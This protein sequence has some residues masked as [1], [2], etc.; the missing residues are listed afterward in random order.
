MKKITFAFLLL[1]I[2]CMNLNAQNKIENLNM[3]YGEELP[4]DKQKIIKIIGEANNKIYALALAGKDDFFLKIFESNSMKIISSNPI[5]IPKLD[6]KEVDFDEIFLLNEKL[7]AIGSV[8]NKKAKTFN[9]VGLEI[10][11][12]GVLGN[13]SILLF[14]S[15]V[16]KKSEKGDFYFK[17]SQDENSLLVMHT[18]LF[19]KE[20][21]VEY[22]VKLFDDKLNVLFTNTEKVK[23][24][25]SKKDYE[26]TISDFELNFENDVFL[27][28]NESYRDS[29]KKEQIE[30][31]QIHKFIKAN[32]YKKEIVDINIKGKEIINC[33]MISTAKHTLKL[34]GFYSSVRDNGKGN[35]DLKGIYNATIDLA[36]S[37]SPDVKFDEFDYATKVKLIGERRAKNGKDVKPLYTITTI[38]EKNDGGLIVLSELQYVYYGRSSG[39]GP[40]AFT[41]VTYTK[42]EI[43]VTSLKPDGSLDWSNV[44]PKEQAATVTTMSLAFG[45]IGGNGSF[46]VGASMMIPLVDL[47]KGPEYLGAI[48]MYKDGKLNVIFNDNVKNKGI[49]DI[50]KIKGLGNYNNAVPSLFIFDESGSITRKDPEEAVKNELVLRPGVYYRKNE[51]ELILY[52]SRKK[53][54]KLGRLFLEK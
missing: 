40:L 18:S 45:L 3:T 46:S 10:S 33:K 23:F 5:I 35:K 6:D 41:P 49:T 20:D 25:D 4:D 30:K 17:L 7:Y 31:F 15:V 28:I 14:N 50:E 51:S 44:L 26:F 22:E 24:D 43:I 21:A 2:C 12:S 52:S 19:K 1:A 32:A 34:V 36:S 42:N 13:K 29:K 38:V 9:L 39:I 11:D 16:D 47:G 53:Q 27:V 37:T 48:P 8:Y 54:D